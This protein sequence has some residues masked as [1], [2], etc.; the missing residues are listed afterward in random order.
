M[1]ITVDY[2]DGRIME[3]RVANKLATEVYQIITDHFAII[4]LNGK[5]L[6]ELLTEN[7]QKKHPRQIEMEAA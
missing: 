4:D 7:K 3:F 2:D 1:K 5:S 6:S